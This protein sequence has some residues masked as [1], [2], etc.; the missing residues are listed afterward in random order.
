MNF[1]STLVATTNFRNG[2]ATSKLRENS[3]FLLWNG[4]HVVR[5]NS[6]VNFHVME[7]HGNRKKGTAFYSDELSLNLTKTICKIG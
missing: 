7:I 4:I 2:W 6:Q 3:L 1:H 5:N